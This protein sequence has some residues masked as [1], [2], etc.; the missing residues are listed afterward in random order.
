M[1]FQWI[2]ELNKYA[3]NVPKFLVGTMSDR[4]EERKTKGPTKT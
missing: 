2:D 3:P 1:L 4:K